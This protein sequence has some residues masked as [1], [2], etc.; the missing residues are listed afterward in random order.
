MHR[1]AAPVPAAQEYADA[2]FEADGL[3]WSSPMYHGTISGAF[4]NALDWLELLAK[5]DPPYLSDKV[6]GLI[7]SAGGAQGLQAVNTLEYAVRSLRAFAVPLVVPIAGGSAFDGDGKLVDERAAARLRH[8]GEE[9]AELCLQ[10][11]PR[12]P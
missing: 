2:V 12:V 4:K 1:G 8:L 10:R 6:V 3:I 9:V 7:G 11:R 5:R